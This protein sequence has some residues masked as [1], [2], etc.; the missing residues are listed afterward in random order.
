MSTGFSHNYIATKAFI[1][2]RTSNMSATDLRKATQIS[3]RLN[4]I[5]TYD[6]SE[7]NTNKVSLK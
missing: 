3:I 5:S 1:A 7:T 4:G 2:Q 6:V